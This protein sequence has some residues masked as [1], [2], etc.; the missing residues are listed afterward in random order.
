MPTTF[1][2]SRRA[3]FGVLLTTLPVAMHAQSVSADLRAGLYTAAGGMGTVGVTR[4]ELRSVPAVAFGVDVR[5]PGALLGVRVSGTFGVSSGTNFS[6]TPACT[7]ACTPRS[8]VSG[9]FAGV[10]ADLTAQRQTTAWT[11]RLGA[12]PGVVLY[13]YGVQGFLQLQCPSGS[14]CDDG[15][16]TGDTR[17]ALHVGGLAAR[18]MAGVA[19]V[20]SLEDY[21]SRRL[22]GGASHDLSVTVGVGLGSLWAR[23]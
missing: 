9:G 10:A 3:L 7:N 15:F 11:F 21:L 17:I 18:R 5:S 14:M 22:G 20:V 6:P 4:G 19:L 2:R 8:I 12:G 13:H 23:R 1:T 16:R